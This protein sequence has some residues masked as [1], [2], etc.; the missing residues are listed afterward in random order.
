MPFKS[1]HFLPWKATDYLPNS[2]FPCFMFISDMCEMGGF[3][4]I[5]NS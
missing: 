4:P 5:G 2:S 1:A 3:T